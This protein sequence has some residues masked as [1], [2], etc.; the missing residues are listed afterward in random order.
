MNINKLNLL[1]EEQKKG[2]KKFDDWNKQDDVG[3]LSAG[4]R[5]AWKSILS[6]IATTEIAEEILM[7][8]LMLPFRDKKSH[9]EY[10]TGHQQDE[11]MHGK[12]IVHYIFQTFQYQKTRRTLSDKILY[13]TLFPA[14]FKMLVKRQPIYGLAILL[15]FEIYAIS[16]YKKIRQCANA[17]GLFA[18]SKLIGMIERD[19]RRH[20]AGAT[21]LFREQ[22]E[23]A[24]KNLFSKILMRLLLSLAVTDLNMNTWALHNR[25][26]RR[27]LLNIGINSTDLTSFA[28]QTSNKIY[29]QFKRGG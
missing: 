19:E 8:E 13:D 3:A 29:Q 6:S 28:K 17:D 26:I 15:F 2:A 27:H 16:F 21:L 5:V 23:A 12:E 7:T 9:L 18:L 22:V 25:K 14:L 24:P 1:I 20:I 11:K 4:K 10:L